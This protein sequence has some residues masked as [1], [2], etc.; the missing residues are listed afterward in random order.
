MRRLAT[1]ILA[2]GLLLPAAGC[3][4]KQVPVKWQASG[5]S[6]A[7]ATV[8]VGFLYNPQTQVP[9]QSDAQAMEEAVKR[10]RAWGYADAEPF[11]LMQTKC[12]QASPMPFGGV[13]CT[14]MMVTRRYQCV[15]RGDGPLAS[16]VD[17]IRNQ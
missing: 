3:A 7:D 15:G 13:V 4:P 5:G 1:L 6:R 12:Q 17:V 16:D 11:G 14:S 2:A 9:Q 10:C 8:E